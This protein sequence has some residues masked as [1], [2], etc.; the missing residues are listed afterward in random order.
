MPLS[1]TRQLRQSS[2][3][4][5]Q[6]VYSLVDAAGLAITSQLDF[7]DPDAA[8]DFTVLAFYKIFGFPDLGGLIV[9][10]KSGHILSWRKYFGGGTVN[11]LTVLHEATVQRKDN[12]IHEGLEDGTLPFHSVMALD[13]AIDD[14]KRLYG[15]MKTISQHTAFLAQRLYAGLSRMTYPDGRSLCK[16]YCDNTA[17]KNPYADPE[18]QGATIAFSVVKADGTYVGHSVVEQ[19]ANEKGIY[20][21]TGGLCN[22]GGIA[23]YLKIEPWQFKRAWSAGYRFGNP[24][25]LEIINGKPIGVIRASLGAMSTMDDVDAL[26]YFL[27]MTFVEVPK[28]DTLSNLLDTFR[29]DSFQTITETPEKDS[30]SFYLDDLNGFSSKEDINVV[31]RNNYSPPK[32]DGVVVQRNG[33][34]PPK[35]DMDLVQRNNYSPPK[36]DVDMLQR[37]GYSTPKEDANLTL[38]NGFPSKQDVDPLR[39][40]GFSQK[41]DSDLLHRNDFSQKQDTD[42]VHR[43]GFSQKQDDD[44]IQIRRNGFPSK[45]NADMLQ[46]NG[47]S[48]NEDDDMIHMNGYSPDDDSQTRKETVFLPLTKKGGIFA[49][50]AHHPDRSPSTVSLTGLSAISTLPKRTQTSLS[51]SSMRPSTASTSEEERKQLATQNV[52]QK[53]LGITTVALS[54]SDL[55]L[56]SGGLGKDAR[57]RTISEPG[58]RK[59]RGRGRGQQVKGS[60]R[61]WGGEK[62]RV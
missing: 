60:L 52:L 29:K 47:F 15:S 16:I 48:A 7:S 62:I 40:N 25:P 21:R 34:S 33:Y 6:D 56:M 1:W 3:A 39:Q 46:L 37:N 28:E 59:G 5:H 32:Q 53:R 49:T 31:Q 51:L 43:N 41:Q 35:L 17:G 30:K 23:S 42:L 20:L 45:Q 19:L 8:P 12:T 4:S 50:V 36:Q 2:I 58:G 18:T 54:G 10:K 61:F 27:L 38:R 22:P 57:S 14:H 55:P 26:L 13:C 24:E 44:L 11:M 9:R